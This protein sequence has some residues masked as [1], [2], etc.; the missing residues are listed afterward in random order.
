LFY[1]SVFHEN[2]IGGF[3]PVYLN[4][5]QNFIDGDLIM[6]HTMQDTSPNSLA[7]WAAAFTQLHEAA[8]DTVIP[9]RQIF[10]VA[11]YP[12]G[13]AVPGAETSARFGAK[14]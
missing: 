10:D 11:A 13:E 8:P 14:G 6:S 3:W 2:A 5:V 1:G 9:L 4:F 12:F 7:G